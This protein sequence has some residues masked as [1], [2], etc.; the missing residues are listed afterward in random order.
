MPKPQKQKK[1]ADAWVKTTTIIPIVRKEALIKKR[2]LNSLS[3][4]SAIPFFH[5][6]LQNR[7]PCTAICPE[8]SRNSPQ[9]LLKTALTRVRS[10]KT[11]SKPLIIP[12]SGISSSPGARASKEKETRWKNRTQE[13]ALPHELGFRASRWAR[14]N[15][16]RRFSDRP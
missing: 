5:Q 12:K 9:L 14:T 6:D 3:L 1:S 15:L 2:Y 10:P 4:S 8:S 11:T 16:D 13:R 7:G